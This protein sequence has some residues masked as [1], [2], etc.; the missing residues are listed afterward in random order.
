MVD[1]A[2]RCRGQGDFPGHSMP[3]RFGFHPVSVSGQADV[4]RRAVVD[5]QGDA[6]GAR[7]K[8]RDAV[9]VRGVE[10]VGVFARDLG[11][12]D[13][14]LARPFHPFQGQVPW[15]G[16][17]VGRDLHRPFIPCG[18]EENAGG[19]QRAKLVGPGGIGVS[20]GRPGEI[21]AF[22][23]GVAARGGVEGMAQTRGGE[24]TGQGGWGFGGQR[25]REPICSESFVGFIEANLPRAGQI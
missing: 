6:A 18:A 7:G 3:D 11:A 12:V 16:G 13:P 9:V 4:D 10:A 14:Q 2:G 23:S 22:C 21:R 25:I 24:G 1:A 20:G 17:A 8:R 15:G 19:R 5:A